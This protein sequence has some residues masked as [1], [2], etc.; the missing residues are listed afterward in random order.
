MLKA[1][2]RGYSLDISPN[3]SQSLHESTVIPGLVALLSPLSSDEQIRN[4]V[5]GG[6]TT[7]VHYP[8]S[9]FDAWIFINP[10]LHS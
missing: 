7:V 8:H 3:D 6:I 1:L 4:V 2:C 10:M 5:S 9:N